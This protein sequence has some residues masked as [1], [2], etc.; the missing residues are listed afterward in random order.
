MKP[1]FVTG[2]FTDVGSTVARSRLAA[3]TM[4][5]ERGR[6]LTTAVGSQR[7]VGH[8]VDATQ[9]ERHLP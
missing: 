9:R 1:R 3:R 4:S 2:N 7:L 8:V 5:G 6:A